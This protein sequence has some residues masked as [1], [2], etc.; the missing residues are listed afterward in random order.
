MTLAGNVSGPD[1][2]TQSAW[3]RW[4][5][6][7]YLGLLCLLALA[8]MLQVFFAGAAVLVDGRYWIVHRNLG[9]GLQ[10]AI[11]ALMLIG[12]GAGLAWRIQGLGCLLWPLLM[13]QYVFLHLPLRF[14][15]PILRALHAVNALLFFGIVLILIGQLWRVL[16]APRGST[17][18]RGWR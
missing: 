1:H 6:W 16:R 5:A 12:L 10:Y 14:E 13:L 7:A 15:M 11:L 2:G 18:Q 17:A 4:C 3:R 9:H 8:I